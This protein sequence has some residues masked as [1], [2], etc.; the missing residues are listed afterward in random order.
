MK[1]KAT[2]K[3]LASVLSF[4]MVAIGLLP[5]SASAGVIDPAKVRSAANAS[6]LKPL[7]N[8]KIPDVN[9]AD[10]LN[11]G[12]AARAAA[13]RLGKALFW[14]MQ[15]G[16]DGQACASCHFAAGADTR[17]RNQL[18]PGLRAVPT[19]PFFGNNFLG[20]SGFPQFRPD[21]T[22]VA[23]DFPFHRLTD[24]ENN[25]FLTRIVTQDTNDVTSSMGVFAANFVAIQFPL[26][27]LGTPFVD[28]IFNLDN[29][30]ASDFN[31][32]VRRVEP[33]NTPTV[34]NAVFTHANFWDGRAHNQF[35]GVS[36]IGP[37]DQGAVIWVNNGAA[38]AV[39]F[40]QQVRIENSSLASQA[41]GPPTS[42]LEMSFFNRPFPLIG[43][44]LLSLTPLGQ[45]LVAADDSVLGPLSNFPAAGLNT[46]YPA[47]IKQA[48]RAKY[49]N[50]GN[51]GTFTQMEANFTLFWG[52]AIQ[53]YET[54]L[55][56]DRAPFDAFM[57]GDDLA[58][59]QSQLQG[60]LVFLNQGARGNPAAVDN[61]IAQAEAALGVV[62]GSGNCISC[63]GGSEFTDAALSQIGKG[64]NTEL[65]EI[66]DTTVLIG[67]L[68]AVSPVQGLLDN[69]FANIGVRPTNDDLG[70][71][72]ME[73]GFPLS[74]VRQALD[75]ALNFLLPP[76]AE[77]DCTVGVNCPTQLMVDGAFKIPGLRNAELTGPYFH[78]GGQATLSQVVEFYDRQGD[79]GDTNIT[80]LDRNMVFIDL[81]E[82]DEDPLVQFL[83]SL[84]DNRVRIQS[85][86]FDHPELRV[87]DGGIF[88]AEQ[89]R[90]VKPA[91]GAA[92]DAA[93]PLLPFLGLTP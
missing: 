8:V 76:R 43:R 1:T 81:D 26:L 18:S 12:P 22:L 4:T 61:A 27:D 36:P 23:A 20:V 78:N 45:Q 50:G 75:P 28:P 2:K 37:L 54:T 16:S 62:I 89:P 57:A 74:F 25:N 87:P 35:N 59:S 83:I 91:V 80:Q 53:L 42:D 33:R 82:V 51:A 47:L 29:P 10:F 7:A 92:G 46:T 30:A 24:P 72:G 31:R 63:H 56:S 32:N 49:W 71:G 58:L 9:L 41:V 88:A 69:G 15:A 5:A 40:Q 3:I 38:G 70:R 79:F 6:G 85:A 14:D 68:L 64:G 39:P 65:I 66:E 90:I 73:G 77:L 48:F 34:I 13:V 67:G 11:P 17:A 55:V 93:S 60:L 21:Y 44:K 84:T 19:D 52:L 86:P